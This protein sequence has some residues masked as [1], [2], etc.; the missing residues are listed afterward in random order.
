MAH[1]VNGEPGIIAAVRIA[2]MSLSVIVP[3]FN[4]E[5]YL[6]ETLA[7]I[8]VARAFA[9]DESIEV[10]VVDNASTDRTPLV[11]TSAGATVVSEPHRNI[12][13]ARNRGAARSTGETLVFIDADTLVPSEFFARIA[14]VLRDPVCLGGAA[15]TDYAPKRKII[16][17]YLQAWRW[18]GMFAG[19][20]Q[21][22][23]QFCRRQAFE[24]LSGYDESLWM[25][26]DVDF[27]LRLKKLAKRSGGG[28]QFLTDVC[29]RPSS[30]RFDRASVA[31]ILVLTN[32][33]FILM[34]QRRR[35]MWKSWYDEEIR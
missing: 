15:D 28:V 8:N 29:V 16:R 2:S 33:L 22:A 23:A 35:S 21:G 32:P 25:G 30:R 9:S 19:I 1:A 14:E 5:A 26:E 4:E 7:S 17:A 11:A 18:I 27:Y 12:A 6:G 13:R 3:A 34:F 10:I 20:A 31:E 24:T